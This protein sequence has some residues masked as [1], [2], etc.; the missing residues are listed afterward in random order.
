MIIFAVLAAAGYVA[1]SYKRN[2]CSAE[3]TTEK[4]EKRKKKLSFDPEFLRQLRSL[5]K[6]MIPGVFSK[7]AGVI[8]LLSS[9]I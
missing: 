8:G 6:I 7:E 4:S 5:L 2:R 9:Y 3:K 1:V